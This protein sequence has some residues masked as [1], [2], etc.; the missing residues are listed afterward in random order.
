MQ[1][2]SLI[3]SCS[4]FNGLFFFLLFFVHTDAFAHLGLYLRCVLRMGQASVFVSE[5]LSS[6]SPNIPLL[7]YKLKRKRAEIEEPLASEDHPY[8]AQAS[9]Q[10]DNRRALFWP[11]AQKYT[12]PFRLGLLLL[13]ASSCSPEGQN[14]TVHNDTFTLQITTSVSQPMFSPFT[15]WPMAMLLGTRVHICLWHSNL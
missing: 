15:V 8:A 6:L 2:I 7:V 14:Q 4:V 1:H 12:H 3:S 11:L 5:A 10:Q 13:E 9:T